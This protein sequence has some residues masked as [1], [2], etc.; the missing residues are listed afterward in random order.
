MKKTRLL[1]T[2]LLVGAA[3]LVQGCLVAAVGV[4]AGTVAYLRGDLKAVE[5]KDIDTV[6]AAAKTA[7]KQL[8][9][10]VTKDTKD[11]MSAVIVARDAQDK[12][13]TITL[14]AP[15]ED[16]TEISVR[17]GIFGNETKSRRIYEQIKENLH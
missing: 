11:E 14:K 6:Y 12:K 3:V 5:A 1:L 17:V 16:T 13:I 15:T 4:G 10:T 9:L 7:A 8:E 2:C